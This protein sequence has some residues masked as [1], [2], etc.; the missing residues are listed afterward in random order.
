M[1]VVYNLKKYY[2]NEMIPN[3]SVSQLFEFHF[4]GN[5]YTLLFIAE[6]KNRILFFVKAGTQ[7]TFELPIENNFNIDTYLP[8]EKLREFREFFEIPYNPNAKQRFNPSEVIKTID[9]NISPVQRAGMNRTEIAVAYRVENPHAIYFDSLIDWD[10]LGN[11]KHYTVK[12]R[13]KVEKLI[14]RLFEQIKDRNITVRFTE[15]PK[16]LDT[17]ETAITLEINNLN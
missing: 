2:E 4:I 5:R 10:A 17:E 9:A 8:I 3:S 1:T 12:N 15:T 16:D 11:G 7:L 13:A 6:V 14:P